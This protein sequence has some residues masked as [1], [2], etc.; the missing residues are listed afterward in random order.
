M[1]RV[2]A[3]EGHH[4][5]LE[6]FVHWR[7][8][9]DVPTTTGVAFSHQLFDALARVGAT[10]TVL[11]QHAHIDRATAG[12]ITVE[13][14]G[15]VL[16]GL[17]GLAYH[18]ETLSLA[19]T[20]IARARRERVDVVMTVGYPATGL[21]LPLL[22][23]GHAVVVTHHCVLWPKFGAPSRAQRL[24]RPLDER[25]YRHPRCFVL[26]VSDDVAAQVETLRGGEGPPITRFF[27]LFRREV[28]ARIPPVDATEPRLRV[29]FIGRI[30][31]SKGVFDVLEA[32]HR[33]QS[34]G[35]AVELHC[36]GDGSARS[37]LLAQIE[38][39]GLASA[40][41][42]H[43]W[44]D[45]ARL[46]AIMADLHVVVA[47]TRGDFVEGFN[48]VV[49]EALLAQR[50]V[51]TSRTCPA[52]EYVRGPATVEVGVE[53][54]D[55]LT[56]ALRRFAVDR[57]L[58]ADAAAHAAESAACFFE[59]AYAYRA[60]VVEV[61]SAIAAQRAPRPVAPTAAAVREAARAS[62]DASGAWPRSAATTPASTHKKRGA[63]R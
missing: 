7:A 36:C 23:A 35:H 27:P 37:E 32:V 51:I 52:L 8:G 61:L 29:G 21:L 53:S 56:E 44:C 58:L 24:V 45:Q 1:V 57:R 41:M 28:F 3:I 39:R 30:E 46:A 50:P 19:G 22:L 31:R 55:D 40:V 60:A 2:L 49:V 12:Q 25:A 54:V 34:A 33:L 20:L 43:G 15:R 62:A 26:A 59:P 16:Y 13:H 18:R 10:A 48:M 11:A 9:R 47:P 5:L 63:R 17:S 38:Q 14:T 42:S 4:G 6:P